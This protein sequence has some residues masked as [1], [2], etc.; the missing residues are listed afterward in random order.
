L[1]DFVVYKVD[2]HYQYAMLDV[3]VH[4]DLVVSRKYYTFNENIDV[5]AKEI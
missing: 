5:K 1:L 3:Q 2:N 4:P